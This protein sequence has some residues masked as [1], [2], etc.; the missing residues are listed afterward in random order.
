MEGG[1]DPDCRR[2]FPWDEHLWDHDLLAYHKKCIALRAQ[3]RAL[4]DGTY[5][6]LFAQDGLVVILRQSEE[7][8]AVILINRS[9]STRHLA[10]DVTGRLPDGLVLQNVLGNGTAQVQG[11]HLTG[12]SLSPLSGAI[13]IG[14]ASKG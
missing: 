8:Q 4:R 14:Q 1:K 9:E 7:E 2:A 3:H 6:T 13:L 12:F 10:V 5:A 11:N